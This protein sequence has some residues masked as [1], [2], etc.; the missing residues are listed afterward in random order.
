MLQEARLRHRFEIQSR[1][2]E[3]VF[4]R[5]EMVA[6]VDGG[7]ADQRSIRFDLQTHLVTGWDR[8]RDLAGE[9]KTALGV[10]DVAFSRQGG[11][12]QLDVAFKEDPP[13]ALLDLLAMVPDLPPH[14]AALGLSDDGR[15]VLLQFDPKDMTHMLL[16]GIK[17]AGKTSLIRTMALSL[18]LTNRQSNVQLL[19]L[20]PQTPTSSPAYT[21]LEPLNF[22]PHMLTSV[23]YGLETAVETLN[24]LANELSYREENDV[25]VP[26][27]MV[28][29]DHAA[30]F[31]ESGG[32]AVVDLLTHLVQ[33]GEKVGIHL[34]LST[35]RPE[36][37]V[38]DANLR[39]NLTVRVVGRVANRRAARDASGIENTGA[40]N[41][42]GGGDFL[43]ITAGRQVIFQAAYIDDYDLHMSL[44]QLQR[45]PAPTLMA[46]PHFI[47][48]HLDEVPLPDEPEE[49]STILFFDA[50]GRIRPRG[51]E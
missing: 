33:R 18:A 11:R 42:L 44:G 17:G 26:K 5:H 47:R 16:S 13:V 6:Q 20:D 49:Q 27:L 1:Q 37:E 30:S 22:L 29:V 39:A 23:V 34:V 45:P 51:V 12:W 50:N 25:T 38:I 14:T 2:I 3:R 48:A 15:P 19:I 40:E 7:I 32:E 46:Q 4:A 10:P 8:L 36:S 28:F 24:F 21:E 43:A 41:L 9:L 35:E 31:M